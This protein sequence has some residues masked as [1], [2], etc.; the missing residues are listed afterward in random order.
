M[1]HRS[2]S[3]K[4][5]LALVF[6]TLAG[7]GCVEP[8]TWEQ[9]SA[10]P[11]VPL[12]IR[13]YIPVGEM[14]ATKAGASGSVLGVGEES[15]LFDLQVWAFSHLADDADAATRAELE[16]EGALAYLHMPDMF[17]K[18]WRDNNNVAQTLDVILNVPQFVID[19]AEGDRELKVDFYVLANGQSVG[20]DYSDAGRLKR[21]E[22][23][24]MTF[25]NPGDNT[26]DWFG[27]TSPRTSV[28]LDAGLPITAFYN[29]RG[30]GYDISF[31]RSN[32][33]PTPREMAEMG[34]EWP[35]I[36]LTRAVSRMRFLFS[37]ATGLTDLSIV[38]VELADLRDE[39]GVIPSSE[40]LFPREDPATV[41][42]L[43]TGHTYTTL[44]LGSEAFPLLLNSS[45]GQMD[46]PTL[47]CSESEVT[48]GMSAQFYEDYLQTAIKNNQASAVNLYL[49]ESDKP[50]MGRIHYKLGTDAYV[51]T[52]HMDPADIENTNFYRNRSWTVYGYIIGKHL[53]ISVE[54]DK[55]VL[56]WTRMSEKTDEQNSVNVDQDG[57]FLV[58]AQGEKFGRLDGTSYLNIPVPAGEGLT[59]TLYIY[60]PV[61]GQLQVIPQAVSVYESNN[62]NTDA[63][64]WFTVSIQSW[65]A[66]GQEVTQSVNGTV[67]STNPAPAGYINCD[68]QAGLMKVTVQRNPAKTTLPD[69][70]KAIM[71]SFKA[72]TASG[73]PIDANS[74]VVDDEYHFILNPATAP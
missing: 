45:I 58:N 65:T 48:R 71:L 55:W 41:I 23:Q 2:L 27:T 35:V 74:E 6:L 63:T 22:I 19:R 16:N 50:I 5:V 67:T 73:K 40:Y 7:P 61:G 69:Q 44:S 10:A 66:S 9:R 53:E 57:R 54:V 62:E 38:S 24:N 15:T 18:E 60:A 42:E 37:Q 47:L 68:Q 33:N 26:A 72:I 59:G 14:P 51:A 39:T 4:I 28:P 11:T 12:P 21:H 20:F 43:P 46:D 8:L 1:R 25:G 49:R 36:T 17:F 56:P 64:D 34:R 3:L 29:N 31:L 13:L 32:K 30:T 52:F 70:M